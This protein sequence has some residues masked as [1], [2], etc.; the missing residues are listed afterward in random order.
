MRWSVRLVGLCSVALKQY[1]RLQFTIASSLKED[2]FD[3]RRVE[4]G[5]NPEPGR[6][7]QGLLLCVGWTNYS[8]SVDRHQ[9]SAIRY[10]ACRKVGKDA[11]A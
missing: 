10:L 7:G 2:R 8:G 3:F 11:S 9:D 1:I 5:D 4:R 6:A